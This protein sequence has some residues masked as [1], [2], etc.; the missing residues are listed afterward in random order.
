M[1]A[2]ERKLASLNYRPS[3]GFHKDRLQPK[4]TAELILRPRWVHS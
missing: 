3:N 4:L 1:D 2:L